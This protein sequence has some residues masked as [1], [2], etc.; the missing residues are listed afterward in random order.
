MKTKDFRNNVVNGGRLFTLGLIL[1]TLG[2][3]VSSPEVASSP[4]AAG[5]SEA[6]GSSETAVKPSKTAESTTEAAEVPASFSGFDSAV[7]E[8]NAAQQQT[9]KQVP[10]PTKPVPPKPSVPAPTAEQLKK[11][12]VT[13][14][15]RLQLLAC[16]DSGRAGLLTSAVAIGDGTTYALAGSR[17]TAWALDKDDST[18]DF[19]DSANEQMVKSFDASPDGKWLASGDTK[20]NLQIWDL[21]DCKLRVGKKIYPSG[22]AY[23]SI[24]PD[25]ATIATT[26]FNGEVTIWDAAQLTPK[27]KFTVAK[28][29][30]KGILFVASNRI[31]IAAQDSSIWNTESGKQEHSLTTGGYHSTFAMSA[32][33]KRLAYS[34]E[35][36]IDIWNIQDGKVEGTIGGNFSDNDLATFSPDGKYLVSASK[37]TIQV[38]EIASA[39]LV[40]VIESFGW[41]TVAL[42]WLPK[43]SLLMIASQNGRV[44]FWGNAASAT[45]L[46]WKP[47]HGPITLPS[48]ESGEPAS[49][50]QLTQVVDIRTLPKLPGAT[51]AASNDM[52]VNYAAP[53][54]VDEAKVFYHYILTR[55]GWTPN[56][57]AS[58]TPDAMSFTKDGFGL[59]IYLSQSPEGTTQVNM[60]LSGN[61][62]LRRVPKFDAVAPEILYEADNTVMYRVKS[63][64]LDIETGLIRKLSA[65]GWT[66]YARLNTSKNEPVDGRD[67]QFIRGATMLQVNIQS[68][69]TDPGSYNISYSKFL[70]TKSLPIPKDAGF[71]EFDGSTQPLMVASTAM[72]LEQTRDFYDKE[73]VAEG[74]LRRDSRKLFDEKSGWMDFIRGQCDVSIVLVKLESGRTQIRVGQDI[75][76]S[77]WQ[78]QKFK[79]PDP[80]VASNGIEA[81]DVPALNG[82]S[83]VKYDAEQKQID[84]V[85]KGATTFAFA[86]AYGKVLESQGWKT[87]GRGVKSDDYLLAE[88]TKEKVEL[89]L[90]ATLRSGEIQASISGDG[91]LWNKALPV[92]KQVIAYETWLRINLHPASLELLDKY[93]AEMKAI[94]K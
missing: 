73:M 70:T 77:S 18:H 17:L 75:E 40:Q 45:A 57:D 31:A 81:A 38:W 88:F 64:L 93:I 89:T 66:E 59:G 29:A 46:G 79:E 12:T 16:R 36:K 69:P 68:Q 43:S 72:T 8:K 1:S 90:R 91:L 62:D 39:Q 49:P 6:S 33:G 11:W 56:A 58:P 82:W 67:L 2:C 23:L 63:D 54:K 50:A 19:S 87:D 13:P 25:S 21:P 65:A 15:D 3:G 41:E 27:N 76:K 71:I 51:M 94:T 10:T 5:S 80:K 48:K 4:K 44:R 74:W 61:V 78:L 55:D 30:L 85:A 37:F 42:R 53:V 28:Q 60:S 92:A 7:D 47:L 9:N 32:D 83:I 24:S 35:G 14:Y 84:F 34:N 26:S 86:E 20:G 52:L 22:V